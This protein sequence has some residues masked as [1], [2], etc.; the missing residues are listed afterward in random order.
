[1][2]THLSK[3]CVI[4]LSKNKLGVE[5]SLCLAG[6]LKDMKMLISLDLSH[7]DIG[8]HGVTQIMTQL[9]NSA[10]E[11]LDL[12]GNSI[13]KS[14][15]RNEAGEAIYTFLFENSHLEEFKAN[16]NNLRGKLG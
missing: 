9:Q 1:M 11:E 10:L 4:N 12:S 2:Q 14:A 16:W 7:N 8:D 5:G 15:K 6:N 3:I 13:G